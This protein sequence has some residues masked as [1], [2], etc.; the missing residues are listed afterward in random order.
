MGSMLDRKHLAP[1]ALSVLFLLSAC[2]PPT[3]AT[4]SLT[5]VLQ[6]TSPNTSKP[7]TL[8][9]PSSPTPEPTTAV[10]SPPPRAV[11]PTEIYPDPVKRTGAGAVFFDWCPNP[12]GLRHVSDLPSDTAISLI[13]GLH[14]GDTHTEKVVTDPAL[15]PVM[16]QYAYVA[17]QI[18]LSWLDGTIRPASASAYATVLAAQCGQG[19]IDYS[20]TA[21]ICPE[22]CS[23]NTS[24]S[25][26]EDYFFLDRAGVF[27]IWFLW[28]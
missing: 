11:F 19:I 2:A 4:P 25:L 17:D 5:P 14:S 8:H 28:P 3:V 27:L 1:G 13:N 12:V 9:P 26:K 24:E 6:L 23:Q 22:P 20:W 16:D 15:W 21:R 7:S 18:D 10:P